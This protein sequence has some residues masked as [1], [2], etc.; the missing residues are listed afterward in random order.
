MKTRG[1]LVLFFALPLLLPGGARAQSGGWKN[2][3][4]AYFMGA[5][6]KGTAAVGPVE[7][8]IDLSA[9]DVLSN[10]QFGALL[11]YRGES[12]KWAVTADV[13]FMGLG[14]TRDG[15][16]G[17]LTA[18]VDADQ[19]IAQLHGS[20]RLTEEFEVLGGAR[21]TSLTSTV[22]LTPFT[23][24]ARSGKATKSWCDPIIGARVKAPVGKGWSLEGYADVGGF[25]IGSD[26]TWM[27]TAR[28]NWQVSRAVGLGLGWRALSQDY[29]TGSGA[30]YFRWD[31]TS[32]GPLAALNVTF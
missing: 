10:L 4:E 26:L 28:V 13:V 29:S 14:A 6:M 7:A 1:L 12:P 27:V 20:W 2:T 16:R 32:Q 5:A 9:S 3:I 18:K 25:G 22:V 30:D 21:F 23:G 8:Q 11:D 17:L 24:N 15:E 31:V 19:W